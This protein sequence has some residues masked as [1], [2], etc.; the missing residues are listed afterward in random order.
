MT[1]PQEPGAARP[2]EGSVAAEPA[3]LHGP[4]TESAAPADPYAA[5]VE[6]AARLAA[7]GL[8]RPDIALVLGSGLAPAA[9]ALGPADAEIAFAGLGGLP[10]PTVAGHVPRVRLVR[11]GGKRVLAFLGRPHLYE[12]HSP[13]TVV[14]PVRTAIAAGCR[15]VVLTNAAGAIADSLRPGDP[16][17]ISD[18]INLTG[19]SPLAG[20]PPPSGLPGRFADMTAVYPVQLRRAAHRV[21]P[22]LP[23]SVYAGLR[24]PQYETPAEIRMLRTC[25][26]GLVGMSTVLE[27]IAARHLG[28][29]VL[30][31]SLVTNI[32]AGLAAE[33]L[34]HADVLDAG[35]RSAVAVGGLLAAILPELG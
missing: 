4:A 22:G 21:A 3:N 30:G 1:T 25:G 9:D 2:T 7:A 10:A 26:A 28:A 32:A 5:A 20:P 13:A 23:E 34:A 33:P 18:H 17:L 12:G 11:C 29:A 16:V 24:G 6:S 31:L 35:Q 27:A 8:G 15:I 14:H 19:A